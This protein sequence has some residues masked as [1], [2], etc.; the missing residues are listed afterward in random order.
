MAYL[1]D[2]FV[3]LVEARWGTG[4]TDTT[5]LSRWLDLFRTVDVAKAALEQERNPGHENRANANGGGGAIPW[6]AQDGRLAHQ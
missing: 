3:G 5:H 1:E 6:R 2:R 4:F